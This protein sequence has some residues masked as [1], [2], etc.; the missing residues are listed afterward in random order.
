MNKFISYFVELYTKILIIYRKMIKL[1]NKLNFIVIKFFLKQLY[2]KIFFFLKDRFG[3]AENNT[4]LIHVGKSGGSTFKKAIIE[5]DKKLPFSIIHIR[6]AV[7]RK[8]SNISSLLGGQL[9]ELYQLFTGDIN[10]LFKLR[11]KEID[12]QVSTMF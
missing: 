5:R 2:L 12:F 4:I 1:V 7:F 9:V 11:N 6:S 8:N 3:K 10:W